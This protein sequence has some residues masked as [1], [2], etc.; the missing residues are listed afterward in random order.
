MSLIGVT[1]L[2]QAKITYYNNTIS[3]SC[4]ECFRHWCDIPI[5]KTKEIRLASDVQK[6]EQYFCNIDGQYSLNLVFFD[7]NSRYT[8]LPRQKD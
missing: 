3:Q 6:I 4:F 2:F 1:Q 7:R 5:S 8:P